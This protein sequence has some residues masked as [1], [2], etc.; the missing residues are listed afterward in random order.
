[1]PSLPT[2]LQI[3]GY[4]AAPFPWP[5]IYKGT[6]Y[7]GA[8]AASTASHLDTLLHS[9]GQGTLTASQDLMSSSEDVV[10]SRQDAVSSTHE[11]ENDVEMAQT[12]K[13]KKK[14]KSSGLD[15]L[16]FAAGWD[17]ENSPEDE[18]ANEGSPRKMPRKGTHSAQAQQHLSSD[19]SDGNCLLLSEDEV[20]V[21]VAFSLRI[22]LND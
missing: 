19:E 4:R 2:P 11:P 18:N 10:S 13:S 22:F 21:D 1:M 17:V 6:P 3:P 5:W 7:P 12:P 16:A 14:A 20:G 15:L 8:S 9:A